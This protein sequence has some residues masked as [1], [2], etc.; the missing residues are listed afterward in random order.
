MWPLHCQY[1]FALKSS[2]YTYVCSGLQPEGLPKAKL[3]VQQPTHPPC[4]LVMPSLSAYSIPDTQRQAVGHLAALG[5]CPLPPK[6][7]FARARLAARTA[8]SATGMGSW[9]ATEVCAIYSD[10]SRLGLCGAL[11]V[12]RPWKAA[13]VCIHNIYLLGLLGALFIL[14]MYLRFLLAA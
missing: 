13:R 2:S 6:T 8:C 7:L 11:V 12:G 3:P 5:S 9:A 10:C 14:P 4:R 1:V